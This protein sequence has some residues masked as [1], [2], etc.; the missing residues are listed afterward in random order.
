MIGTPSV[1]F[2]FASRSDLLFFLFPSSAGRE[3]QYHVCA[4]WLPNECFLSFLLPEVIIFGVNVYFKTEL[5]AYNKFCKL[6]TMF[7]MVQNVVT[8]DQVY[9]FAV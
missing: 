8:F 1:E 6:I 2:A 4:S 5:S 9:T 3:L 7:E